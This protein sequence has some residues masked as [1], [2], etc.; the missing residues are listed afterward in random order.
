MLNDK[1]LPA[2]FRKGKPIY[3]QKLAKGVFS[4]RNL[5]P[6]PSLTPPTLKDPEYSSP[7]IDCPTP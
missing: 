6:L 5:K 7:L 4:E 2:L 1:S 3:G